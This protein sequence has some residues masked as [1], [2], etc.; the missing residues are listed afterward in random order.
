MRAW[1]RR[2]SDLARALW[3]LGLLIGCLLVGWV[4]C[5][6]R[7]E[8][9]TLADGTRVLTQYRRLAPRPKYQIISH[10]GGDISGGPLS[11]SGKRHGAWHVRGMRMWYWYGEPVT[12][13]RFR[14]WDR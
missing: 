9:E 2:K 11:R 14:Q 4:W 10:P 7:I 12:E 1:W 13:A 3:L 6:P 5:V 8:T